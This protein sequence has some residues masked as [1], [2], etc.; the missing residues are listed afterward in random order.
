M[1][2]ADTPEWDQLAEHTV[3]EAMSHAVCAV[4][5]NAEVGAAADAI[6]A[7]RTH[8]ALVLDGDDLVGIVSATDIIRAVAERKLQPR[9][10]VFD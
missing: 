6:L 8:R 9:R 7:A 10:Y 5:A 3:E 2:A 1:K 4:A